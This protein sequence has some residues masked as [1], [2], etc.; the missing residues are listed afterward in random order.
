MNKLKI[1]NDPIY[2]LIRIPFTLV[3]D[4]IEHR[5][6]QRLR[7]IKQMGLTHLVYPGA[8][9]TRFHHALGAMH[10]TWEAILT[11]R[12]KG[13]H[14]SDKEA[15]SC[16]AA[17]LLHDIGHGPFSHALEKKFIPVS[18]EEISL[19]M[20]EQINREMDG[21]LDMGI[22]MFV[23][24]YERPFF[25]QLISSQLD[26]DRI[27]YLNRDSFYSGVVEGKIGYDR[28]IMMLHVV[29]EQLVVEEKAVFSVEKYLNSRSFMYSQVYLH[30][31]S[32]AAECMLSM[33]VDSLVISSESIRGCS[34]TVEYFMGLSS[35]SDINT[36]I[37]TELLEQY[38]WLDDTDI[39]ACIKAN[40]ECEDVVVAYLAK[41][42]L[43][44]RLFEIVFK[45]AAFEGDFLESKRHKI[46][47][48]LK[49]SENQAH[50]LI[51]TGIEHKPIYIPGDDEIRILKK[52]GDVS[53][54]S[55]IIAIQARREDEM[56]YF[57]SPKHV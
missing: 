26:M 4:L 50:Q 55:E 27:D 33:F 7:R 5:Y 3:Y 22:S 46:V 10:I 13:V 34:P 53:K 28:I 17:I 23:G 40:R 14:I 43:D 30:H 11:L 24:D 1:I 52:D 16:L 39:V 9:H 54:L 18:H 25:H 31:A 48:L 38:T 42:L 19:A 2:G 32:L 49:C 45:K 21:A 56:H 35:K 20:M 15:Q 6:F 12:N 8:V 57:C 44:R 29:D 41:S 47:S 36:T 51:R 37:S